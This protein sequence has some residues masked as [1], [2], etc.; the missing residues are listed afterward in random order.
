[1]PLIAQPHLPAKRICVMLNA[2]QVLQARKN[3]RVPESHLDWAFLVILWLSKARSC[4]SLQVNF[5]LR[6]R[7]LL[8]FPHI[9]SVRQGNSLKRY[10]SAFAP[11]TA[12]LW[13]LQVSVW[14]QCL[15]TCRSWSDRSCVFLRGLSFSKGRVAIP[16][17]AG[18]WGPSGGT[19]LAWNWG[20]CG[21]SDLWVQCAQLITWERS[22]FEGLKAIISRK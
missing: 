10:P 21:N 16:A 2:G 1:M 15:I 6:G 9:P 3:A 11:G 4:K 14:H 19:K 22:T 20:R 13:S 7:D 5:N 8:G 12:T 17:C 18:G